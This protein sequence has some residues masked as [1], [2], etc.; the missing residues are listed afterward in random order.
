MRD[1]AALSV[2]APEFCSR[3]DQLRF[4]R[5]YLGTDSLVD[6]ERQWLELVQNRSKELRASEE[7]RM[8]RQSVFD[9]IGPAAV[10]A[11]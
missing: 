9:H 2:M 7:Q 1:L 8:R 5:A 4:I 3:P 10:G 6:E 11:L